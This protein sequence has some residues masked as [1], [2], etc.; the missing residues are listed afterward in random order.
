MKKLLLIAPIPVLAA[1]AFLIWQNLP[2]KRYAKHMTK[3]RLYA[4]ENNLSAARME[5]EKAYQA[6]GGYSPYVSLEVLNLTNRMSTQ[7]GR[8]HEALANTKM[9]VET[10]KANK[11]GKVLLAQLAFQMGETETAFAALNDLFA[12]DP[13][14]FP[15]R[16]L[17]TNVRAKQGRL[18]LAEEQLR[19]LYGKY[20]DSVQ[21]LMPLAEILL[22]QRRSPESREFLAQVLAKDPKHGRARLLMVDSYLFE[23]KLDSAQ[24]MLDAWQESDP[25]QKQA[26]QIR[27]ARLYSMGGRFEEAKTALAPYLEHKEDNLQA[28]AE[29][30]ILHAKSGQYDSALAVYRTMGEIS[31]KARMSAETMS[32]YLHMKNQNPARALEAL[33]TIRITDKRPALLP[34]M[35]AA[36]LAIDQANKAD[37]LIEQQPDSIKKSLAEF[38]AQMLPDREFIGQWAIITYF[39]AVK[40]DGATFKAVQE[41]YKKWPK[42]PM[43]IELWTGQLSAVSNFKEAA[44]VLATLPNPSLT[45]RV[46]MLQLAM[47]AGQA[48]QGAAAAAKLAADFPNLKGVNL[49]LADY[50]MRKDK[51]KAAAFYEKELALNPGNTV[52]LNNLAWEY[53]INQGNLEKATPY[54]EKLQGAKN[55]DPRILDTIGWILA[56][57]GKDEEGARY[58]RNA[59]DLV[60]DYPPF[61]YHMAVVLKKAGKTEEARKHLESALGAKQPFD[62]R[63]EAEKLLAE[64]G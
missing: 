46:A 39:G 40:Q 21:A 12:Q 35:I 62:E 64:L 29:L 11:D 1:A 5:Y 7:E 50:W 45:H 10:H 60:P 49:I 14:N 18:D 61:L 58:I 48:E 44:K 55:L 22:R 53:G 59:L 25:E 32:F 27:K 16:L 63:Q 8:P 42:H 54:L 17:L 51:A 31:P 52:V 20:P 36:Y 37:E 57:N 4:K 38:K 34:P 56:V 19:Y 3:A 26:V 23:G 13:W 6:Q 9:F 24:L 28:M 33:K 30:A 15:A 43:A 41:L 2:E 47:N